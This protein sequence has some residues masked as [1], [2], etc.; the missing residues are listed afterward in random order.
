VPSYAE[1][2]AALESWPKHPGCRRVRRA[3]LV[4]PGFPGTFN[5]SYTEHHWLAEYGRFVDWDH[6][7]PISTVQSCVRLADLEQI[8]AGEDWRYLGVFEMADLSG[9]VALR[10]RPEYAPLY[11]RQAA[12]VVRFL[13]QHGIARERIHASYCV[14]GSVAHLTR[15]AYGFDFEVPCDAV[16]RDAFLAAG[17]PERNLIADDTRATLL[18]LHIHR[19]TPWGHR[20][21][22]FVEVEGLGGTRLLDVATGEYLL[23]N[24]VFRGDEAERANLVGLSPMRNGYYGVSFGVERLCMAVN[25]LER[26]QDV[27]CLRPFYDELRAQRG[28]ALDPA[29]WLA[30]ESLRILHRIY[31]DRDH[32]PEAAVRRDA[33]G[34]RTL[35][36]RRRRKLAALKRNLPLALGARALERLLARH[37]EAQ[38]WH[39][40][41][42]KSIEVVLREVETYRRSAARAGIPLG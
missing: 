31:T 39:A 8:A 16:C 42:D 32:H 1:L 10:D 41:L 5:M 24:P 27:D 18:S 28:R 29:D 15:G 36:V 40:Y 33:R 35:S 6:D 14:G 3:P 23:W 37:A 9:E 20:N 17:V 21:E 7:L 12:E 38:P 34:E 25:G 19:A 30:G 4:T 26:V 2:R 11:A 22:I 13:E